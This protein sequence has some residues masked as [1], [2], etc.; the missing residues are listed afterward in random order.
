MR[1]NYGEPYAYK[2]GACENSYFLINCYNKIQVYMY[3]ERKCVRINYTS[4]A[5]AAMHLSNP[6][7]DHFIL[8]SL[9]VSTN[10]KYS[11]KMFA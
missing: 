9:P 4:L 2:F 10:N 11:L 8:F 7:A 1:D 3:I 6:Q 5:I